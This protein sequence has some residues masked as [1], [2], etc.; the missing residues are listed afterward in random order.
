MDIPPDDD[1]DFEDATF[2]SSEVP[3]EDTDY[4]IEDVK[5]ED[6]IDQYLKNIQPEHTYFQPPAN[7]P[8]LDIRK[9]FHDGMPTQFRGRRRWSLKRT[10]EGGFRDFDRT[11]AHKENQPEG[12]TPQFRRLVFGGGMA[13]KKGT[14]KRKRTYSRRRRGVTDARIRRAINEKE[15]KRK[16]KPGSTDSL[17]YYGPLT[18]SQYERQL[19]SG[20]IDNPAEIKAYLQHRYEDG[21][22]G[23]GG[24]W[25]KLVKYLPLAA[26]YGTR[27]GYAGAL[28]LKSMAEGDWEGAKR[29]AARGWEKGAKISKIMGTGAYNDEVSHNQII[30]SGAT[31]SQQAMHHRLAGGDNNPEGDVIFSNTEFLGNIYAEA[32]SAGAS[33]FN[34]VSYDINV[35]LSK[36]FPFLS[37]LA[38]NFEL[39][40]LMGLIF[41]YK[42]TSGEYGNSN[43]NSLGKVIMATNY[44]PEA[45]DFA[46]NVV[47]ENYDYAQ[48]SKPSHGMIHG[49]E[50]ADESRHVKMHYVRSGSTSRSKLFTDYGKFQIATQ[51]IPFSAAGRALVGE[52]WV[53]YSVRLSRSQLNAGIGQSVEYV[54]DQN[55]CNNTDWNVP[56]PVSAEPTLDVTFTNVITGNTFDNLGVTIPDQRGRFLMTI[57]WF[58]PSDTTNNKITGTTNEDGITIVRHVS[59]IEFDLLLFDADYSRQD[60]V[61]FELEANQS[62]SSLN[63]T[64]GE[65]L[66]I[67]RVDPEFE[68]A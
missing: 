65:R 46:N 52:L 45:P 5:E 30:S 6:L 20:A 26:K 21:V 23:K 10:P 31:D 17:N 3:I 4:K 27:A 16:F 49:V 56:F 63:T 1:E 29:G 37:Q 67:T 15:R 36:T 40:E 14:R 35:G 12:P 58:D 41:Q 39:Y 33:D 53:S 47:M 34:L 38:Q 59:R 32:S 7:L 44:D 48:S 66:I 11:T 22:Y 13:K 43:S 9:Q 28:A 62:V 64:N 42:P 19:A 18:T 57:F 55:I 8:P 25:D 50:C 54:S 61:F 68:I 51:G 24:Y 60:P 2:T